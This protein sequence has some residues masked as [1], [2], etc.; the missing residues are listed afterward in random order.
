MEV[1][2]EMDT[3]IDFLNVLDPDM[4]FKI[5]VCL[6]DISDLVRV[7]AVSRSWRH[8]GNT[9]CLIFLSLFLH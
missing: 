9:D 1:D 3:G 6:E 7:C 2:S 5:F 8:H 4:S